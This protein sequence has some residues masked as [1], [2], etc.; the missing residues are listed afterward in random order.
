MEQIP[1]LLDNLMHNKF[2]LADQAIL[3]DVEY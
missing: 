1:N 3:M 2:L